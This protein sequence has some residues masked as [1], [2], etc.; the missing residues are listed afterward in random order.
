MEGSDQ[1]TGSASNGTTTE[2]SKEALLETIRKKWT[3]AGS[4]APTDEVKKKLLDKYRKARTASDAAEA[5]L[6]K[7]GA[8]EEEAVKGLAEAFG[9]RSLK[10]DGIIHDFASRGAK[11]YFR[12]RTKDADVVE[13]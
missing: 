7:A 3:A 4:K 5:A 9:G 13:L 12:R 10:I 8:D 6:K 2:E 1:S 11:I